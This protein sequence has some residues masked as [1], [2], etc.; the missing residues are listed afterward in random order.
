MITLTFF[1]I[2]GSG[3]FAIAVLGTAPYGKKI[4][5]CAECVIVGFGLSITQ[6]YQEGIENTYLIGLGFIL[7]ITL[8]IFIINFSSSIYSYMKNNN[9]KI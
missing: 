1:S 8:C 3:C 5:S 7:I 4:K 9:A 6:Y 2:I